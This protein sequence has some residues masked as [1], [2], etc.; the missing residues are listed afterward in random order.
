M[1]L[2][3]ATLIDYQH[4]TLLRRTKTILIEIYKQLDPSDNNRFNYLVRIRI[5]YSIW[6]FNNLK[7]NIEYFE[8]NNH[9]ILIVF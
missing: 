6:Y 7:R 8:L 5:I 4:V 3:H 9:F 1:P 2:A